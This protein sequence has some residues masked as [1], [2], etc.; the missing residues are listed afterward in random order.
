[1]SDL[2]SGFI[3]V[4][5]GSGHCANEPP[6]PD[7]TPTHLRTAIKATSRD[8]GL[9][10]KVQLRRTEQTKQ[11][12][13]GP[14]LDDNLSPLSPKIWCTS[15]LF[16]IMEGIAPVNHFPM[17]PRYSPAA[18]GMIMFPY[19]LLLV[20]W[21]HAFNQALHVHQHQRGRPLVV[22]RGSRLNVVM[23]S[24]VPLI[25]GWLRYPQANWHLVYLNILW[26]YRGGWF[27]VL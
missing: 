4:Q 21:L 13:S 27:P 18:S 1:M 12:T 19:S 16:P 24:A 9:I 11:P 23:I 20:F 14:S 8:G 10:S 15:E 26:I 5:V 25:Q 17:P 3:E 22:N 2:D 6:P 7:L